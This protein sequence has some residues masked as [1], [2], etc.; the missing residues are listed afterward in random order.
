VSGGREEYASL[1][2]LYKRASFRRFR[3]RHRSN[4]WATFLGFGPDLQVVGWWDG[5]AME[6]FAPDEAQWTAMVT[7]P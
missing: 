3:A 4:R 5:A 2:D 7:Y 6:A 1:R